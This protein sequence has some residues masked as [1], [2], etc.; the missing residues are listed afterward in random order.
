MPQLVD[1][2][3]NIVQFFAALSP[4]P[5]QVIEASRCSYATCLS[6]AAAGGT[7]GGSAR[8]SFPF[9]RCSGLWSRT[10]TF[11]LLVV[12]ELV[13]VFPVFSQDR[14]Q[15]R[16]FRGTKPLIFLLVEVFKVYTVDRVEQR[17]WSRSPCPQFQVEVF[18]VFNPVQGSAASSSFSPSAEGRTVGG[19][20]DGA[21]ICTGGCCRE[22]PGA[23]GI[24][25]LRVG[26]GEGRGWSVDAWYST[27]LDFE[28]VLSGLS[29]SHV[30]VFVAGVVKS[31]DT[32]DRGVLD[33]VL[34]RLGLPESFGRAYFGYHATVRP[35]FKL[36]CGL[37]LP[38]T[39]DG[40]IPQGCPLSMVF[41]RGPLS[42][43]V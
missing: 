19:S 8:R 6:R 34:G 1:Q 24:G 26:G 5:E 25:G 3:P 16:C 21:R 27:A 42:S 29:E 41:Y 39:R 35:R 36:A 4:V 18:K 7:A 2:L 28:E 33:L 13:E 9:P 30:H 14:I 11:Q 15:H 31:F 32:V 38:W 23:E 17:F 12:V 22:N 20:A 43:L 10:L 40:G 37:G